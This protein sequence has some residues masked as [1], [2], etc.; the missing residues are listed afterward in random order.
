MNLSY[1]SRDSHELE[2]EWH[3]INTRLIERKDMNLVETWVTNIQSIERL[4]NV[5]FCLYE[6]VCDT[7]C[8]G[9]E[10]KNTKIYVNDYD[11]KMIQKYGYYL[12]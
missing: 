10:K 9:N 5:E 4:P 11:Y 2:N 7:N 3:S 6:I 8:Y 12:N 1:F